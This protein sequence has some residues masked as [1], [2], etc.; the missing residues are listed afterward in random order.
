MMDALTQLGHQFLL[1]RAGS[2]FI[3]EWITDGHSIFCGAS[4]VWTGSANDAGVPFKTF[5]GAEWYVREWSF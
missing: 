4:R 5:A 2:G 3:V 1:H